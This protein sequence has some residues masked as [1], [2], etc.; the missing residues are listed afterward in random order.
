MAYAITALC[1]LLVVVTWYLAAATDPEMKEHE[2]ASSESGCNGI[3]TNLCTTRSTRYCLDC[4]KIVMQFDHH[5]SFLNNCVGSKNYLYF[6]IL[7]TMAFVQMLFHIVTGVVVQVHCFDLQVVQQY[8]QLWVFYTVL[9][10]E[11]LV[12]RPS[13]LASVDS[14]LF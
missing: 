5:C 6:I 14:Y 8:M 4:R 9:Q 12:S 13:L 1:T 10:L 3:C 2:T 7:V 11:I